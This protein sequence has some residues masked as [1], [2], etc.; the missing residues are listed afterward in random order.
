MAFGSLL[1]VIARKDL[2]KKLAT[3]KWRQ[4]IH[5]RSM[6]LV[7]DAI[8]SSAPRSVGKCLEMEMEMRGEEWTGVGMDLAH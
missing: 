4:Q 7:S 8:P 5:C 1:V 6:S 3:A 2:Q